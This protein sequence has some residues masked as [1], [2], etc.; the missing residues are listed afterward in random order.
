MFEMNRSDPRS[1]PRRLCLQPSQ[2]SFVYDDP[3]AGRETWVAASV[4]I[5]DG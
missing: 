2:E 3:Q 5:G 1:Y 4:P